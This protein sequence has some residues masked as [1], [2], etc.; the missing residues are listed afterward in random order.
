MIVCLSALA[1]SRMSLHRQLLGSIPLILAELIPG[2]SI[3]CSLK[4]LAC[5][6]SRQSLWQSLLLLF[7]R[8]I[9]LCTLV[10]CVLAL[11]TVFVAVSHS[12]NSLACLLCRLCLR[13][14][15][16]HLITHVTCVLAL[17]TVFVAASHSLTHSQDLH[18][19]LQTD[20]L[21]HSYPLE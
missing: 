17:Q 12:L 20:Y 9:H 16:I 19:S 3:T 6:F 4:L 15:L 21:W 1:N 8:V 14:S 10:T 2:L 7:T 13:Q 11:Q 5:S 18:A